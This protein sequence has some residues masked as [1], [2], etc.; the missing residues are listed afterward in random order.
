MHA[1]VRLRNQ[2]QAAWKWALSFRSP[3]WKLEDYPISLRKQYPDPDAPHD[4]SSRFK[5]HP[6]AASIINWNVTGSGESKEEALRDLAS[7]FA[8][9]KAKLNDEGKPLPRPGTSVPIQFASQVRMKAHPELA[10]DFIER[11]L[12][13][14][15]A[16]ISVESSLWD[17]HSDATNEVLLAKIRDVYGVNTEDIESARICEILD[18]IAEARKSH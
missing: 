8:S 12:G 16:F 2:L 3:D 6:I 10:Q 15:W 17:F 7:S 14:E 9:R 1:A 11:V 5:L 13:F 18:R 4:N